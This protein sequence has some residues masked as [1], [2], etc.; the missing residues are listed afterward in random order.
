MVSSILPICLHNV[1]VSKRGKIL[2]GPLDLEIQAGGVT[3]V[4]GPNGSGKTTLLRLMSGLE[5]IKQ[6]SLMWQVETLEAYQR[7]AVVFQEPVLLRRSV[8]ENIAYPLHLKKL[9]KAEINFRVNE[10]LDRVNLASLKSLE[11]HVVSGGEKQKLAIARALVT[12]PDILFLDEPTAN[13][14]GAST[15]EI[16]TLIHET[17]ESGVK[18]VMS[19]HNTAQGK[20]LAEDI[21]FLYRGKLHERSCAK[22]FFKAPKT[23]EAKLFLAGEILE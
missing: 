19:T 21:V 12:R 5:Q 23:R 8:F 4:F 7:Q 15:R 16:E 14:D 6:G 22:E 9:P 17:A 13:L 11:A 1:L 2:L 18:V 10:V 20:R 3:V